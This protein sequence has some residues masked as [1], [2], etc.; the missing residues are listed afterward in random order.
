MVFITRLGIR[1]FEFVT[2]TQFLYSDLDCRIK[3]KNKI[4]ILTFKKIFGKETEHIPNIRSPFE[5]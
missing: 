3:R 5:G 1:E 2:K 4:I